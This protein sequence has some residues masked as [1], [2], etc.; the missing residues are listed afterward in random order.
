MEGWGRR[1]GTRGW[2]EGG[3]EEGGSKGVE[4]TRG[5]REGDSKGEG[6]SDDANQAES[7]S[8]GREG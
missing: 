8:G 3:R 4:G 5:G 2:M 1:E 6:G 7:I